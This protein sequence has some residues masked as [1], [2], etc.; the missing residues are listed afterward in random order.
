M[1]KIRTYIR[2]LRLVV[3][4]EPKRLWIM[5]GAYMFSRTFGQFYALFFMRHIINQLDDC[6]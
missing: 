6:S 5:T 2:M 3:R 4:Y 1:Q